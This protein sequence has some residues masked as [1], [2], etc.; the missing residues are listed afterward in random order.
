MRQ[1]TRTWPPRTEFDRR[2]R[3]DPPPSGRPS[4]LR[5]R[6]VPERRRRRVAGSPVEFVGFLL[7]VA[8]G[9]LLLAFVATALIAGI[10]VLLRAAF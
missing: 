5:V 9:V 8:I 1:D 4:A 7:A 3:F 6:V 2:H 10:A